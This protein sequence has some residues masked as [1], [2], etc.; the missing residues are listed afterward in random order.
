MEKLEHNYNEEYIWYD[1]K[2]KHIKISIGY[3]IGQDR[4]S[5][6]IRRKKERTITF[7][8]W[9][10]KD[11]TAKIISIIFGEGLI[12][13]KYQ[14]KKLKKKLYHKWYKYININKNMI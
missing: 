2:Y 12:K 11:I 4:Y 9:Y 8:D 3:C 13:P 14:I 1:V 7:S 5:I 6:S 10:F